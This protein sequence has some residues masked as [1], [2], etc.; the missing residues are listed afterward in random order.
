MENLLL[1]KWNV[2][3][4][5]IEGLKAALNDITNRTRIISV[6]SSELSLVLPIGE[7]D[8]DGKLP[9]IIHSPGL[10]S[11][12]T[13]KKEQFITAGLS[14]EEWKEAM[15]RG[16][17][18]R[19]AGG[20][21]MIYPMFYSVVPDLAQNYNLQGTALVSEAALKERNAYIMAL[22]EASPKIL[23]IVLRN[24][25]GNVSKALSVRSKTY[26]YIPQTVIY[27]TIQAIGEE[28]GENKISS[29]SM[30]HILT[31]V[32]LDFPDI[33]EDINETYG[34]EGYMASIRIIDSDAAESSFK[35]QGILKKG[36]HELYTGGEL[37]RKHSGEPDIDKLVKEVHKAIFDKFTVIPGYLCEM[38]SRD[39]EDPEVF[40]RDILKEAGKN[41]GIRLAAKITETLV[42][43]L[44]NSPMNELNI[45][46]MLL[47]IPERVEA[48]ESTKKAIRK[49]LA[50][51]PKN[52]CENES[53][54]IGL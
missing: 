31:E 35:V 4:T 1:E 46:E 14:E 26:G 18:I 20:K 32:N 34:L 38:A 10:T 51:L 41:I 23:S 42:S 54:T 37:S 30:N 9:V 29:W 17:L 39:V 36:C 28:L 19:E 43:E 7:T 5:D 40:L 44:P 12:A 33:S 52:I 22:V 24:G 48:P 3:G 50:G 45:F 6:L 49:W 15:L 8:A 2:Q 27:D 53:V 16:F 25:T 11:R 47:G 21:R 13:I